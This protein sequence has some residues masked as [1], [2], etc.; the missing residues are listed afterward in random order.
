MHKQPRMMCAVDLSPRSQGA[1]NHAMALARWQ[2][3]P[4]RIGIRL[5]GV[6][7]NGLGSLPNSVNALPRLA[8]TWR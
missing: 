4:F 5:A 7:A 2:R 3:T 1:L 8:S 6:Y